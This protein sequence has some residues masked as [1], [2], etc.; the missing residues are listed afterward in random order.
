MAVPD[1]IFNLFRRSG[2]VGFIH[3]WNGA[4]A[5]PDDHFHLALFEQTRGN[6]LYFIDLTQHLK[7]PL[8][9]F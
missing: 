6:F 1:E 8:A 5:E 9:W 2:E 3:H 4:F 7:L